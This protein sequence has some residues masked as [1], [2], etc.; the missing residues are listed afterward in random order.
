VDQT[1][2][3]ALGLKVGDQFGYWFDFGDDWWHQINVE[4]V[5]KKVARGKYP[6]VIKR[7]GKS[8]PQYVDWDKEDE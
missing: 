2:L 5:E 8:P 6:R 1:T 3:D 4:S 7:V